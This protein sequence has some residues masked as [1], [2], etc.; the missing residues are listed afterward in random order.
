MKTTSIHIE[1]Q[2]ISPEIFDRLE[3]NDI[4]GQLPQD[5]GFERGIR[6]KDEIT[7]RGRMLRTSGIFLREEQKDLQ[8][9]N[10][11]LPKQENSGYY[12]YLNS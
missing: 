2:I 7:R 11:V 5:F 9:T 6:V 10:P 1:G 8:R 3:T 12:R 4:S